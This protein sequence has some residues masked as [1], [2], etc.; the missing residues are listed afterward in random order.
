[1]RG[2]NNIGIVLSATGKPAEA[3]K[4]HEDAL[5]IARKLADAHPNNAEYAEDLA[6]THNH[7][8]GLL[9]AT[10]KPDEAAQ[11]L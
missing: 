5:V 6:S 2:Q 9:I 1:M 7:L 11:G 3:L 4:A 8:G 10:G